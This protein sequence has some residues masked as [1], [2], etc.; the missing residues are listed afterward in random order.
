MISWNSGGLE[1][2]GVAR[3]RHLS[4]LCF[5]PLTVLMLIGL[6]L[7]IDQVVRVPPESQPIPPRLYACEGIEVD[8]ATLAWSRDGRFLAVVSRKGEVTL[9]NA[10]FDTERPL[11]LPPD[12][13]EKTSED[14]NLPGLAWSW[15]GKM[16]ATSFGERVLLWDVEGGTVVKVLKGHT[17]PVLNLAFTP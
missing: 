5:A 7:G 15:D 12:L 14:W 13:M 4:H 9:W 6:A 2:R 16:L 10:T 11:V 1:S 17:H 3:I 8:P